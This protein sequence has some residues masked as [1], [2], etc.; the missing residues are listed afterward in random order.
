MVTL[1]DEV[2]DALAPSSDMVL[3]AKTPPAPLLVLLTL[4]GAK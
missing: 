1:G 2:V 3:P 4:A